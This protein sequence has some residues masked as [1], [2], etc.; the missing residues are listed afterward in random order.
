MATI[1]DN[2]PNTFL[3]LTNNESTDFV[4]GEFEIKTGQTKL[5][6]SKPQ[7]LLDKGFRDFA[8]LWRSG[9]IIQKIKA[10]QFGYLVNG[11]TLPLSLAISFIDDFLNK[12]QLYLITEGDIWRYNGDTGLKPIIYNVP[13]RELDET[14]SQVIEIN[15]FELGELIISYSFIAD[16]EIRVR[17]VDESGTVIGSTFIGRNGSYFIRA[18]LPKITIQARTVSGVHD[19]EQFTL[20]LEST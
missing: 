9:E 6:F 11:N 14:W 17:F 19:L 8:E 2:I 4:Y 15:V 13:P 3:T 10:G 16:D 18:D 1:R 20:K 12:A 7:F 5:V